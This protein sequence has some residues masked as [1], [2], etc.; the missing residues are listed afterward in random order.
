MAPALTNRTAT[1]PSEGMTRFGRK[2]LMDVAPFQAVL[3]VVFLLVTALQPG[4][5]AAANAMGLHDHGGMF[6]TERRVEAIQGHADSHLDKAHVAWP[7]VKSH[8]GHDTKSDGKSCEVHCAPA[9]AV[10]AGWLLF[11][12]ALA[13]CYAAVTPAVLPLWDFGEL[14]RPPKRPA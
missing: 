6:G 8:H 11:E 12:H 7:S 13:R 4:L 1:G 3:A 5:F 2:R 14:I 9:Q 10:P